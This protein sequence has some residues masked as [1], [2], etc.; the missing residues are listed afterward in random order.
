MS[1]FVGVMSILYTSLLLGLAP[2]WLHVLYTV[3]TLY[4]LP[5]RWYQYKQKAWHYFLFD[6]CYY[7]NVLCLLY[8]WV[9]PDSKLLWHSC[10]LL[11]H[12]TSLGPCT[13][14]S[15]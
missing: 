12:G 9:F 15:G 13:C 6:L 10:Y 4:F 2:E 11:S 14:N 1:F 7:V 3:Q 8:I 5:T